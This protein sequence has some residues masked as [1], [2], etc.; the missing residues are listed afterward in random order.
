MYLHCVV[1]VGILVVEPKDTI[2]RLGVNALLF[3]QFNLICLLGD[4]VEL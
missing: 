2:V 4:D 1:K 3:E